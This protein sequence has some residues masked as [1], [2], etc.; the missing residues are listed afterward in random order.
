MQTEAEN[1]YV[2]IPVDLS[3]TRKSIIG[4]AKQYGKE[5]TS[6]YINN[7]HDIFYLNRFGLHGINK[8]GMVGNKYFD[9]YEEVNLDQFMEAIRG[10]DKMDNTNNVDD[11]YNIYYEIGEDS[12]SLRQFIIELAIRNDK[13][14][15]ANFIDKWHK[16]LYLAIENN[17]VGL[18]AT[19][20]KGFLPQSCKKVSLEEFIRLI[21]KP[22][23]PP[24]E[25]FYLGCFEVTF[26]HDIVSFAGLSFTYDEMDKFL[27]IYDRERMDVPF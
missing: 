6:H 23:A 27:K 5:G 24:K 16:N 21:E 11:T 25:K 14:G 12:T 19:A 20:D 15:R 4:V 13:E 2:E 22:Y 17:K 1:I 9:S 10:E 8:G 7:A 26:E 3:L 18:F